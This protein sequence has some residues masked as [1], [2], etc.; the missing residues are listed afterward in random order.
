MKQRR[1]LGANGVLGGRVIQRGNGTPYLIVVLTYLDGQSTLAYSR[2]NLLDRK[3]LLNP[4]AQLQAMQARRGQYQR[5]A[6]SAVQFSE[7]GV[8]VTTH[9]GQLEIVTQVAQLD[10]TPQA[11][12]SHPSPRFQ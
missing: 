5:V 4:L 2:T 7:P 1:A 12:R 11:A 8:E 3:I 9:R 6:V 10:L